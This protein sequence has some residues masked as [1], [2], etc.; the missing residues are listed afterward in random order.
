MKVEI[1]YTKNIHENAGIYYQKAKDSKEKFKGIEAAIEE[2]KKELEKAKEEEKKKQV[3]VKREKEWYE[4]FHHFISENNRMMI[5]GR[6]AQQN[7]ILVSKKME[8]NDLFFHADIQGGSVVLLKDG[9]NAT[10]DE[11]KEAAQFAA[12]FS[13]AWKNANAAVDVYCAKKDQLTK[14]VSGGFVGSGAFAILGEREWFRSTT[15]GLKIGIVIDQGKE[16]VIK[17]VI[18]APEV[19]NKILDQ[20]ISLFP[21][22]AGYDK[23]QLVKMISKKLNVHPDELLEVLPN[24]KSKVK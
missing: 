13:N 12:S 4:K 23:G 3:K 2:T 11:K 16:G 5:G 17:R 18:I 19:S 10:E 20:K 1:D 21:A 9:V 15:L 8:E 14:K 7:D 6:N 24:G 22:H